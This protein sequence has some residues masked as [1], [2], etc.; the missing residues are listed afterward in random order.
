MNYNN[1]KL[2]KTNYKSLLI[3][4]QLISCSPDTKTHTGCCLKEHTCAANEVIVNGG[5]SG[6]CFASTVTYLCYD[7]PD[8]LFTS[9]S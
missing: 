2:L 9:A 8:G 5:E 1:Y 7:G 3:C 4:D 6:E